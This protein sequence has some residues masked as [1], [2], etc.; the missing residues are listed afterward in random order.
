M[1][2]PCCRCRCFASCLGGLPDGSSVA[3]ISMM[4]SLC[5]ITKGHVQMFE[6]ARK[7]VLECIQG[8]VRMQSLIIFTRGQ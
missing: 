1:M 8:H 6:E 2:P 7:I 3:V 5:P 4:G